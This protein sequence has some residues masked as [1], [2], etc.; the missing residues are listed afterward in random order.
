M[1]K[2]LPIILLIGLIILGWWLYK[3]YKA[4]QTTQPGKVQLEPVHGATVNLRPDIVNML[5]DQMNNTGSGSVTTRPVAVTSP[6]T[7]QDAYTG[8]R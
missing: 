6:A 7:S 2:A 3:R 8:G 1:K 4:K 5:Q